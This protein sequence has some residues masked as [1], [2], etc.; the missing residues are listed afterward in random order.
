MSPKSSLPL[1]DEDQHRLNDALAALIASTRR[2]KRKL[3][4][5]Q[6]AEKLRVAI[7]LLGSPRAVAE[8]IGLSDEVVRQFGRVVKLSPAVKELAAR[9]DLR[10][11]DLMDRLSRLPPEDQ[12]PV[13]RGVLTHELNPADVRAILGI[14]RSSPGIKITKAINRVKR[15]RNIREYVAEFAVP[16]PPLS[17]SRLSQRV[18]KLV[19]RQHLRRLE[20]GEKVGRLV[21]DAQGKRALD[22]AARK[23]RLTKREIIRRLIDGVA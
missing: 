16:T 7:R 22:D 8:A 20:L 23:R 15:S 14:R 3:T 6:V 2:G 5:V 1:S 17:A 11:V 21:L 18:S 19:G 9:G 10:S 4:L 12:M 13:A